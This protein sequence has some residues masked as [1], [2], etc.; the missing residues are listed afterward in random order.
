M[1]QQLLAQQLE[2]TGRLLAIVERQLEVANIEGAVEPR[3]AEP[4]EVVI[5]WDANPDDAEIN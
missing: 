2:I 3:P 1:Q 5:L 4:E